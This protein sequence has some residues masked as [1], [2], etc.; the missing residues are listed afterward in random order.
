MAGPLRT[1]KLSYVGDSSKLNKANKEAEGG[2]SKLGASFAKFG[3]AAALGAAAAGAAAG[4]AA[5]KIF[6]S[7]EVIANA[8]DQIAKSAIRVGATASAYQELQFW[9]SQNGIE[10]A[11]LTKGLGVLNQQLADAQDTSKGVGKA[12]AG[13]NISVT[14]VNGNLRN[15][16]AVFQDAILALQ[17]I[18]NPALRSAAAAEIFGGKIARDLLP[19][20][21]DSSLSIEEAAKRARELGLV[22]GDEQL[23]ASVA[24]VDG[25]DEIRRSLT[26]MKNRALGPVIEFFA[27]TALPLFTNE[28]IPTLVRVADRIGPYL[29][30][31]IQGT[32]SVFQAMVGFV[33][34]RVIPVV[35]DLAARARDLIA[36][37]SDWWQRVGPGVLDSFRRLKQ[38]LVDLW[39]NIREVFAQFGPLLAAF[40]RGP[41]DGQGFQTFINVLVAGLQV[42]VKVLGFVLDRIRE[43]LTFITRIVESKAFQALLSGLGTITKGI[44]GIVGRFTG[45]GGDT[46]VPTIPGPSGGSTNITVQAGIGDPSAIAR[47]IERVV[48]NENA[49][50]GA[51][52]PVLAGAL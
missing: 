39:T 6:K 17:G 19:A 12:L 35:V 24:F 27:N 49:R 28:L 5:V 31:F 3:K 50:T 36:R 52:I 46:A 21:D 16:D 7:A 18:E 9:A 11:A 8:N 10:A 33:R 13:F 32:V 37:F 44:G 1:L 20:L 41:S 42:L 40:R 48:R 29:Q 26:A 25:M 15:S 22:I 14:D 47:E 38:P 30:R 34:E 23:D 51:P 4:A 45:G 2:L 43:L